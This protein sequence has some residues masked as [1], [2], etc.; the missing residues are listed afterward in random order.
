MS[1]RSHILV[2]LFVGILFTA[3]FFAPAGNSQ[4]TLRSVSLN[5]ASQYASA[6]SSTSLNITDMSVSTTVAY[7]KMRIRMT[8]QR[9]RTV[10]AVNTST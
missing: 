7:I 8:V 9:W 1:R 6:P 4:S 10:W 2:S 3:S 5:G